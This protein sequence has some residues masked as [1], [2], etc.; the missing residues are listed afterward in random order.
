MERPFK[1]IVV[2]IETYDDTQTW[3]TLHGVGDIAVRVAMALGTEP[4]AL[5]EGGLKNE[6]PQA[7]KAAINALPERATLLV[8][9]IGHGVTADQ[10][11]LICRD[12]PKPAGLD[13]YEA[14]PSGEL[15]RIIANSRAERVVIVLDT[16]YSGAGGG[17]LAQRYRDSL[18][19]ALDRDGWQRVACVIAASHPLSKAVA[20]RFSQGVVDVLENPDRHLKWSRADAYIDPE[21]LAIAVRDTLGEEN[22]EVHPRFSK[23][24][25][26]QDIIPNPLFRPSFGTDDLET[27]RHLEGVFGE[28][29]HFNL[30][31][32]GIEAGEAGFFFTGRRRSQKEIIQWIQGLG[33]DL[34]IVTGPPGSGKSALIGRIVTLSVPEVRE[35]LRTKGALLQD[36]P[37]PP[38]NSIHIAIH[39]KGKSVFQVATALG[40]AIKLNHE[41]TDQPGIADVLERMKAKGGQQTIVIDALDEAG[42]GHA[43]RIANEIIRPLSAMHEIR[44]LVGTRRSLNGAVIPDSE[45]RHARLVETFGVD[46]SIRDLADE[47]ET[48]ND[49]AEFVAR[50]LRAAKARGQDVWIEMAKQKV[51]VAAEGSF[52][53]ARLVA[54]NLQDLP[55]ASLEKLPVGAAAAFVHDITSRFSNDH[56]RV[57]DMLRALAFGLGRGLS[58]AVWAPIASALAEMERTYTD[59]DV[60]WMLR[61]VGSYIVETTVE[62]DGIGQA[63]YRLIHQALA[64]HL[65][66]EIFKPSLHERIFRKILPNANCGA[67]LAADLYLRRHLLEHAVLADKARIKNA[68]IHNGNLDQ[69]FQNP[70]ILAISEPSVVLSMRPHLLSSE[71]RRLLGIYKL[72]AWRL[73]TA[74]PS[75]RWSLIHLTGLMQGDDLW[76]AAPP[77]ASRW[78][79]IW[80]STRPSTPHLSI[81]AHEGGVYSVAFGTVNGRALIVSSGGDGKI[82]LWDAKDGMSIGKPMTGHEGWIESV[83]I[84]TVDGLELIV[85]GGRD[86]TIRRWSPYSGSQ[87]GA[88]MIGHEGNVCSVAIGTA[89]GRSIIISGGKDGT[90]RRWTAKEGVPIGMPITGH[91]GEVRSVAL[92][93][94]KDLDII[95]SS[96]SDGSIR[97]WD[98]DSGTLVGT[99]IESR[100]RVVNSVA[101]GVVDSRPLI[102][103]GGWEN[104]VQRWSAD[105][106]KSI[107][108]PMTGHDGWINSVAFFEINGRPLVVAGGE[109]S[110][111][112]IWDAEFGTPIGAPMTGHE[113]WVNSVA[114]GEAN[115]RPLI[116]SGGGEGT[117]RLWDLGDRLPLG[118]LMTNSK[119]WLRSV[120]LGT[121][122]SRTLIVSGGKGRIVKMLDAESGAPIGTPMT[123]HK[124]WINSIALGHVNGRFL[125][126][127][128]ETAHMIHLWDPTD[129]TSVGKIITSHQSEILSV[130]IGQ[131]KGRT[132][133]V[134]SGGDGTVRRWDA[135]GLGLVGEPIAGHRGAVSSVAIG[136]VNGRALIVSGGE[137]GTV[138]MWDAED[139]M[140]IGEPMR[141]H[142][143]WVLKVALGIVN[144]RALIVSGGLDGT[145]RLWS[146][147]DGMSIGVL[148]T[149]HEYGGYS[150]AIGIINGQ[151]LVVSGGDD[152]IVRLWDTETCR[153]ILSIP[154]GQSIHS[155]FITGNDKICVGTTMGVAMLQ[156]KM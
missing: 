57:M 131:V 83:A 155:L 54:R 11:Y 63:V 58:R 135:G 85:S 71:A 14:I 43:E 102:F 79:G 110:T 7:L 153:E 117:V 52:L 125:V 103:S 70:A 27:R 75:E 130:S 140:P 17:N 89:N 107:G 112:Q 12:S 67:W 28:Q 46:A 33:S 122:N 25:F 116:V 147:D 18:A 4:L 55:E 99:P 80:A 56:I 93:R 121:V 9:W 42:D 97:L 32:R 152:G 5:P 124:G 141:G 151:S 114:L 106:G 15:G 108:A 47:P 90:V 138:R 137:D 143:K 19:H 95:V 73:T 88:P 150:V 145:V 101:L 100:Q 123:G 48:T 29:A 87:I 129:G 126:V 60:V 45:Q 65:Q 34:M 115:G 76:I 74:T 37:V 61:S 51:A 128:G 50:R 132:L 109:D 24:G 21:R 20:G 113:G 104:A 134:S 98:A 105:D 53:Y 77:S 72:A 38:E 64:E 86:G 10:H 92:G 41:I 84:G 68:E 94:F 136:M 26:G 82:C 111:I 35:Q 78:R 66:N 39:A 120:A 146:A 3:K 142:K 69:L 148:M 23:E 139:G 144:S 62:T 31:A 149:G 154:L 1:A 49:I 2:G 16:C 91:T 13:V 127:A 6:V 36:D 44:V 8:H 118:A 40:R 96:S 22:K 156:V 30:A 119:D 81:K 133:I 59:D